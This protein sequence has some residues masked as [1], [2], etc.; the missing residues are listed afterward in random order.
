MAKI[1]LVIFDGFTDIDL[2]LHWDLL[3]RPVTMFPDMVSR[4]WSVKILG[5]A[6]MHL[7]AAGLETKTHGRVAEARN[8]DA[9]IHTSGPLTRNLM[10]DEGYLETLALDPERQLV[11][12]Q[13]SGALIL[14]ASGLL[15]GRTATT[16]PTA[17]GHLRE[18][19]AVPV[20]EPFVL[21]DA[22]NIA[23]AAG[24]LAG[25]DLSRWILDRL[26][27]AEAAERCVA[28]ASAIGGG[29]SFSKA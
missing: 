18:L 21:H 17:V 23:T 5:T 11:G 26:I 13:C 28:S 19:G 29:L 8:C 25:V 27:N 1:G 12:S 10:K 3:N 9:V 2:F 22:D 14:A 16:Y 7:S 15:A 6:P 20:E 4:E 24:C